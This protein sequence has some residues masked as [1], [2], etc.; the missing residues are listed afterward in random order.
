[1]RWFIAL[2]AGVALAGCASA[3]GA[4]AGERAWLVDQLTQ[5]NGRW[6]SRDPELLAA[7]YRKM[8]G[9]LYDFMRGSLAV[10]LADLQRADAD[11]L[12][13]SFLQ[14]PASTEVLLVGDPHL[15][16][17]GTFLPASHLDR[18]AEGLCIDLQD[19][20]AAVHGPWLIDLRRAALGLAVL[21]EPSERCAPETCLWPAV[22]ALAFGYAEQIA[23]RAEGAAPI[24]GSSAVD[25]GELVSLLLA[26]ALD[27][28]DKRKRLDSETET[29]PPR[30]LRRDEVLDEDGSGALELTAAERLRADVLLHAFAPHAPAGHRVLDVVRLFGRGVSSMPAERYVVLWD[31][32]G[33]SDV[34]DALWMFR[35]V[36]DPP[37]VPGLFAPVEGVFSSARERVPSAT[38]QLWSRPDLD[39]AMAGIEDGTMVFKTQ[40]WSGYQQAF[41]HRDVLEQIER[42]QVHVFDVLALGRFV[43]LLLADAHA[44]A[45]T[46]RGEDAAI[47]IEADLAGRAELLA[48]QTVEAAQQDLGQ[49]R[50]WWALAHEAL[51]DL[52]P[53]LGAEALLVD[54]VGVR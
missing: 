31:L 48:Q 51:E 16:N 23:A 13:T 2:V 52:G 26:E 36:V 28:G 20:D 19:L 33:E 46:L 8:D 30:S 32:G 14:D 25:G 34:D 1:M 15:E 6:L 43:G 10:F 18:P 21:L 37:V 45:P 29:G 5:D 11:R 41:D 50:V 22:E 44:N 12:N 7:K 3:P 38:L 17:L 49:T 9:S 4:G 53:L 27:D 35:E 54:D 47:V 42:R 39:P 24:D 40:I